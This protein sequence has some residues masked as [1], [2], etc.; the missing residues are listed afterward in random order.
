[1]EREEKEE[2]RKRR[3]ERR[4]ERRENVYFFSDFLIYLI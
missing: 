4:G 3:S 2:E 1:M